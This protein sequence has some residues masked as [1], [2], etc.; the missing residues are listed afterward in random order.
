MD[1]STGGIK[2]PNAGVLGSHE[3]LAGATEKYHGEAVER[4]ADSFAASIGSMRLVRQQEKIQINMTV[5]PGQRLLL[6][7]LLGFP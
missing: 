5:T 1:A 3:S 2:N 4:E 6:L 7:I